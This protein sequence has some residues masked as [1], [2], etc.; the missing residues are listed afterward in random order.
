[1]VLAAHVPAATATGSL[2]FTHLQ[3]GDVLAAF[4]CL[5]L[6]NRA[7][8]SGGRVGGVS[9]LYLD[10]VEHGDYG[11]KGAERRAN[12]WWNRRAVLMKV[13]TLGP[14]AFKRR[15]K[16]NRPKFDDLVE[17]IKPFAKVDNRGKGMA[18]K[19]SGSFV[20]ATLQL[21]AT[22]RWFACAHYAYQEDN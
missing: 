17:K 9:V 16:L 18:G 20:P 11:R 5:A 2:Y 14:K 4:V 21:A 3:P 6:S 13:Y 15:F 1:M 8:G 22:F 12:E 7:R 10:E 19:S